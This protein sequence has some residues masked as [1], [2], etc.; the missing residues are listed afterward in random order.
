MSPPEPRTVV[1]NKVGSVNLRSVIGDAGKQTVRTHFTVEKMIAAYHQLF[2]RAAAQT[3][4]R[5]GNMM[6]I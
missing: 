3:R 1:G 6:N 2:W 4:L 5:R